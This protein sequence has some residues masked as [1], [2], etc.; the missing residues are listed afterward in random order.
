MHSPA[1]DC[2]VPH[3]LL[4]DAA[5]PLQQYHP[6]FLAALLLSGKRALAAAVLQRLTAWLA[7]LQQHGECGAAGGEAA[8]SLPPSPQMSSTPPGAHSLGAH[9]GGAAGAGDLP[10][11]LF[12]GQSESENTV[13][14][15]ACARWA[16]PRL[17]LPNPLLQACLWLTWLIQS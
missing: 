9:G 14:C 8:A 1:L 6:T 11:P 2:S 12:A 15:M 16:P 5:G 3:R 4:L 13:M 17:K 7:A 10:T